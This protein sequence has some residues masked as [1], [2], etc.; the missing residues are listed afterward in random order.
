MKK[1]YLDV[2]Q[3]NISP[4]YYVYLGGLRRVQVQMI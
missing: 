4:L 3:K 1:I 2:V